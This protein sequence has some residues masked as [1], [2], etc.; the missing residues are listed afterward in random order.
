MTRWRRSLQ[1]ILNPAIT[2]LTPVL[3]ACAAYVQN[4]QIQG[5]RAA[6]D[7]RDRRLTS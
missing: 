5:M 1:A 3:A 4:A 2:A 7:L 6:F